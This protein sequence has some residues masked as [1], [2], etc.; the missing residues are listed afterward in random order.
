ML[1]RQSPHFKEEPAIA[2]NPSILLL[3]PGEQKETLHL[4]AIFPDT[5]TNLQL[6]RMD[7][8]EKIALLHICRLNVCVLMCMHAVVVWRYHHIKQLV[9]W[10]SWG[11]NL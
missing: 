9:M 10:V 1:F 4:R 8:L 7:G 2:P 5:G 11:P 6:F 3:W